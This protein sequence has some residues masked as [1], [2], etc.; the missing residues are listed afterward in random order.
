MCAAEKTALANH[1]RHRSNLP[2]LGE[3]L[4]GLHPDGAYAARHTTNKA[5]WHRRTLGWFKWD[6]RVPTV[7]FATVNP[8]PSGSYMS[9]PVCTYEGEWVRVG[10]IVR[11]NNVE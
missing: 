5:F 11:I 4:Q 9:M 10:T 7:Y 8:T 1:Q 6:E 3:G 2:A